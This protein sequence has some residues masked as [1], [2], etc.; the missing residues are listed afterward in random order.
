M[1]LIIALAMFAIA[2]SG[3]AWLGRQLDP[4]RIQDRIQSRTAKR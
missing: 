3:V 2:S 1:N 4:A